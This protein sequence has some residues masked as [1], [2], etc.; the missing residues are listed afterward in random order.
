MTNDDDVA[1]QLSLAEI[2][3]LRGVTLGTAQTRLKRHGVRPVGDRIGAAG[4]R[5]DLY[6]TDE[7]LAA[8]RRPQGVPGAPREKG[9]A[10]QGAADQLWAD[11][12]ASAEAAGSD[13][14]AVTRQ[15]WEWY[16][17][18]PGVGIPERPAPG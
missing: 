7:A 3:H 8:W 5:E 4:Q 16:V 14:H 12:K 10:I 17:G 18:R 1:E 11:L 13:R 9:R 6:D 2:A 15:F